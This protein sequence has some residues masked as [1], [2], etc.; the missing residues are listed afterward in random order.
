[1]ICFHD[2]VANLLEY[3]ITGVKA[4]VGLRVG[5]EKASIDI[6]EEYFPDTSCV[7]IFTCSW[8]LLIC[9][10]II[11]TQDSNKPNAIHKSFSGNSHK[12]S[13]YV[14]WKI[15]IDEICSRVL[16]YCIG[17]LLPS[18]NDSK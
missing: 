9:Y 10:D 15:K 8:V 6:C 11:S 7:S 3:F 16:Y 13:E 5:I 12:Y 17:N 4:F 14:K 18:G 2:N 1:M